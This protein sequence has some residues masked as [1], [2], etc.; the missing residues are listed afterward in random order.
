M[1]H[2][3]ILNTPVMPWFIRTLLPFAALGVF[4]FGSVR[5][6]ANYLSFTVALELIIIIPAVIAYMMLGYFILGAAVRSD[7]INIFQRIIRIK[8][9]IS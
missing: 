4:T 9:A 2:Q 6:L 8:E 3:T 5:L 7:I 1:V